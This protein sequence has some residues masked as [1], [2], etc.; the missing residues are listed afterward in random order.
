[1]KT[2]KFLLAFAAV[3]LLVGLVYV[4]AFVFSSA[5]CGCADGPDPGTAEWRH[6]NGMKD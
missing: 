2:S 6:A 1:M 4:F 3:V 5:A